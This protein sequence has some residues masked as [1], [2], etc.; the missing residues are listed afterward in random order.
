[1]VT[2]IIP[3]YKRADY[4]TRA[5]ESVLNQTYQ[6]FELI[7]VD[8]NNPNTKER[9][10]LEK[11]IEPYLTNSKIKFIQHEKNKNGAAARNTAINIA[12]GEYITFLDDDDFYLKKRLEVLVK[13]LENNR[14]YNAAYTGGVILYKSIFNAKKSGNGQK[15][16]L[17]QHSYIKTGS[18]MFFRAE[19]LKKLK[20]FDETFS[21]HQDLEI[22]IRFF[23]ENK[24]L[25][26]NQILVVKDNS[27]RINELDIRKAIKAREKLM[28]TFSE[29]INQYEDK[30]NIIQ[31]NYIGL[32]TE[33]VK[34]KD[35]RYYYLLKR[36]TLKYGKINKK[37]KIKL[38]IYSLLKDH[39]K[40]KRKIQ[41]NIIKIKINKLP[42]DASDEIKY[43]I[44]NYKCE[45]TNEKSK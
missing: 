27:S 3:T 42:K 33:A 18:N 26:V 25:A 44:K 22:M 37:L 31:Q 7:I 32:L 34:S 24:I 35:R 4:I 21:R 13:A 40:L 43:I 29:D 15:D 14:D 11:M 39:I 45:E 17:S 20:G 10:K 28:K 38:F 30:N 16:F 5:I 6:D 1:M 12:K 8:D 23:R 2:V 9:S 19:A 41:E 36:K